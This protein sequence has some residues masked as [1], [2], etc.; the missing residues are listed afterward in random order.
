MNTTTLDKKLEQHKCLSLRHHEIMS[1]IVINNINR[2]SKVILVCL[3]V[4]M[5]ECVC[6]CV[7]VCVCASTASTE[8][9]YFQAK[10]QYIVIV[11]N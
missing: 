4:K 3:L 10:L 1:S 2:Q 5:R 9:L 7:C 6:V 8:V 11:I